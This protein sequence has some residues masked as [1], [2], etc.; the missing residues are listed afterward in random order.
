[1]LWSICCRLCRYFDPTNFQGYRVLAAF[2][3]PTKHDPG[4]WCQCLN[5]GKLIHCEIQF[6]ASDVLHGEKS[7][8][9]RYGVVLFDILSLHLTMI[10]VFWMQDCHRAGQPAHQG[11]SF[12]A[13]HWAVVAVQDDCTYCVCCRHVLQFQ[14]PSDRPG[15]GTA[16]IVIIIYVIIY[17]IT[18]SY[19][20]IYHYILLSIIIHHYIMLYDKIHY[21]IISYGMMY[22]HI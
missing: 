19:I 15:L 21:C 20:I 1:M 9:T 11:V 14:A 5:S 22:Y 7:S 6:S 10:A 13:A 12:F 16:P 18:L 2:Q 8:V 17:H 4:R 3:G